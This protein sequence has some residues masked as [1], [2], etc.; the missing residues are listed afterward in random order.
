VTPSTVVLMAKVV[1]HLDEIKQLESNNTH[2]RPVFNAIVPR[3]GVTHGLTK[4]LEGAFGCFGCR[5][6]RVI[7]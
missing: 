2:G 5:V 4:S 6:T 3:H 1:V 7:L